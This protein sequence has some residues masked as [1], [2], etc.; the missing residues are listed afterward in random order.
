MS[1]KE[2]LFSSFKPT[3]CPVS[4]ATASGK[5]S[6]VSKFKNKSGDIS[7]S[8]SSGKHAEGEDIELVVISSIC[9]PSSG[10]ESTLLDVSQEIKQEVEL[11]LSYCVLCDC[12]ACAKAA[13][14]GMTEGNILGHPVDAA[15]E[16]LVCGMPIKGGIPI[17]GGNIKGGM[18]NGGIMPIKGG[19]G[20]IGMNGKGLEAKGKGNDEVMGLTVA[21]AAAF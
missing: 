8:S 21:G 19:K 9:N 11:E 16:G 18:A 17:K 20:G 10:K 2:L 1:T 5:K 3:G 13:M 4:A 15:G 14:S 6:R 7:H 12:I